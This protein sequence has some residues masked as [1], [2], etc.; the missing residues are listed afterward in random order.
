MLRPRP[1]PG[2]RTWIESAGSPFTPER[3]PG[4]SR[5][6][7]RYRCFVLRVVIGTKPTAPFPDMHRRKCGGRLRCASN[8][9]AFRSPRCGAPKQGTP[10]LDCGQRAIPLFRGAACAQ[11]PAVP[12]HPE[13]SSGRTQPLEPGWDYPGTK[14]G[15]SYVDALCSSCGTSLERIAPESLTRRLYEFVHGHMSWR[16]AP[17]LPNHVT[18]GPT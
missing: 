9:D 18:R 2:S 1:R 13:R 15:E 7:M 16:A 4:G 8:T 17:L 6:G 14:R 11:R 10:A 3:A 12:W 5:I